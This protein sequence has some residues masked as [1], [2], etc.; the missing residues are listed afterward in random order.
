M[1]FILDDL[2]IFWPFK[3][4]YPEQIEYCRE[5]KRALDA[6]GGCLLESPTG[7]GKTVCLLSLITS[8]QYAHPDCGKLI[9]CTRTVP[10]M[11]KA[12]EELKLVIENRTVILGGEKNA[13]NFL[14]VCL[15]SRQNMCINQDVIQHSDRNNIDA[16]CRKKTA[17]WVRIKHGKKNNRNNSNQRIQLNSDL[18]NNREIEKQ[19]TKIDSTEPMLVDIEDFQNETLC[20]YYENYIDQGSDV[21]LA[22]GIYTIKEMQDLGRQRNWCPYFVTRHVLSFANVVV[23]NYQYMLDPKVSQIISGQIARESIVVFDEAHN[24]DNVCIEALSINFDRRTLDNAT[25][26]TVKLQ[27]MIDKL[28]ETGI[29]QLQQEYDQL[30]NGL[31]AKGIIGINNESETVVVNPSEIYLPQEILFEAIPGTIRKADHFIKLLDLIVKHLKYRMKVEKVIKETPQVFLNE[32]QIE[33]QINAKTL[34]F[35]YSRLNSL[36]RT[37][38]VIDLEEFISISAV[39]DFLT[40]VSTSMYK[41]SFM[42]II[43]PYDPRTPHYF[44]PIIQFTCLDASLAIK[45]VLD[46]FA[47]VVITSGTLSPIDLYPKLLDFRPVVSRSFSMSINR[48]S[49]C[50]IVVTR[51]ND[52]APIS[53]AFNSRED[54]SVIINYGI[55]LVE[56][57]KIVPDGIVCFFT[58]YEY[59]ENVVHEWFRLQ[60]LDRIVEHKL[61]FIETKDIVETTLALDNYR[62]ACDCGRGAVFLS[63]ARGKVSE[64]IDFD[65]HYG[66]AVILFWYTI[67]IYKISYIA[68]SFR[69]SSYQIPNPRG[70]FSYF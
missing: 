58:S 41:D 68:V 48:P 47:T 55:L 50:P 52:Q 14:G 38:K 21:P 20:S 12:M 49:I 37:L 11:T 13:P 63:I 53:S 19:P 67:S 25:N 27:K 46:R 32:L 17:P 2:R 18:E 57:A 1:D 60:I 8:Y 54:K 36:L 65:R 9:F 28:K 7:T 34:Q 42:I 29:K 22:N 31:S 69:I 44:D 56:M 3:S 26:N 30:V 39:C 61:L 64:G 16:L 6:H 15:S 45:P 59:M 40:L 24:I 5:L 33:L 23:Y 10:E 35:S 66:R 62:R 51:G 4:I 43:E 70:R